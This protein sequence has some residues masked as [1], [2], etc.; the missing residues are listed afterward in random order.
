MPAKKKI[1][2]VKEQYFTAAET[3]DEGICGHINKHHI[4]LSGRLEAL[5]CELPDGH[6]GDHEADYECLRVTDGSIEQ[7]DLPH[8]TVGGKEYVVTTERA[9]WSDGAEIPA[10]EIKPDLVQLAEIKQKRIVSQ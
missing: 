2:E 5:T 9:E 1:D 8:K 6:E 3:T 10:R 4:G 7:E